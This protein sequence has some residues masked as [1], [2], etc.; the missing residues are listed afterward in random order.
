[1]PGA[2]P[3]ART[4]PGRSPRPARPLWCAPRST[5]T[6][7]SIIWCSVTSALTGGISVTCRRSTPVTGRLP[8]PV[9]HGQQPGGS[10]G[11]RDQGAPASSIVAPGWPFGR[12]GLRPVFFRS[13]FGCGLAQPV[14]RWRL[15][16]VLR[17]LLHPRRQVRDL[18]LQLA[19][20]A[21]AA[22][23]SRACP[24]P[25]CAHPARPAAP[26]AARSQHEAR[27]HRCRERR[28]S[29][30]RTNAATAPPGPQIGRHRSRRS[31]RESAGGERTGR[32]GLSSYRG[33]S[34][35][36]ESR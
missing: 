24:A 32:A 18:R 19:P 26:A 8:G 2:R 15:A 23:R 34:G 1:M 35:T 28:A 5:G 29:R 22:P 6:S 16:G 13:D 12:P 9:P 7:R 10:C 11:S 4:A 20:P 21:P 17:V 33:S 30:A 25:R 3:A 27:H 36:S 31:R 14:R